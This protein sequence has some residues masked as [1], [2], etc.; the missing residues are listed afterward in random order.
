M[1]SGVKIRSRVVEALVDVAKGPVGSQEALNGVL[2]GSGLSPQDRALCT[3]ILYGSLRYGPALLKAVDNRLRKGIASTDPIIVWT[4]VAA[5]YQLRVLERIPDHAVVHTAVAVARHLVGP[6]AGKL[7][8]GVL[9]TELRAMESGPRTAPAPESCYPGYIRRAFAGLGDVNLSV[10]AKAYLHGAP[11]TVRGRGRCFSDVST[12]VEALEATGVKGAREGRVPGS[13]ILPR[14]G[15]AVG[16]EAGTTDWIPQD[17]AS[18]AVA[19]LAIDMAKEFGPSCRVLDACAGRGVKTDAL[20]HGLGEEVSITATDIG[21]RKLKDLAELVPNV[22]TRSVDWTATTPFEEG[23]FDFILLD[24][25]C[26]GFGTLR[27]RPEIR[28][29]SRRRDL[30]VLMEMQQKVLA[31]T[32]K[33][34]APGGVLLFAVC[35]FSPGEAGE[36]ISRFLASEPGADF[37]PVGLPSCPVGSWEQ[38]DGTWLTFDDPEVV[39]DPADTFFAGAIRRRQPQGSSAS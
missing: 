27:R 22:T 20:R 24:S 14:G 31:N 7:V 6:H 30:D 13:V 34:L 15:G 17:E 35:T 2:Q 29:I 37:E 28:L 4:L 9:R 39:S 38:A 36:A 19:Q 1:K 10:A 26:S 11:H 16:T 33:T 3:E 5:N 25:P 23:S 21:S 32:A 12:L 18:W 8:N